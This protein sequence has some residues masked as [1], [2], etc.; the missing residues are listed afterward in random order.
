MKRLI[1]IMGLV[2][3]IMLFSGCSN[4]SMDN[5]T[6]YTSV[7]PIE[8]VTNKDIFQRGDIVAVGIH[9]DIEKQSDLKDVEFYNVTSINVNDFGNNPHVHL[10]G[11]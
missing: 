11:V 3:V 5:I 8:Y 2:L 4:D 9:N 6:I 10:G 7:Y 1:K